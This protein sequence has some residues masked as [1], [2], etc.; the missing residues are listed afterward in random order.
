ME[1]ELASELRAR[2]L[3]SD[4]NKRVDGKDLA[5]GQGSE[6]VF[7]AESPPPPEK[8]NSQKVSQPIR[9]A[10]M[11]LF[12]DES[13]DRGTSAPSGSGPVYENWMAAARRGDYSTQTLGADRLL[14][15]EADK[16]NERNTKEYRDKCV[17]QA[18]LEV[19]HEYLNEDELQMVKDQI[20]RKSPSLWLEGSTRTVV[21]GFR[22]DVRTRGGPIRK[23]A[24]RLPPAES[25]MLERLI[26]EDMVRGQLVRIRSP[27]GAPAFL[28]KPAKAG[29]IE[30]KRRMVVDYRWVNGVTVRSFFIVPRADDQK[31]HVAG[32][33]FMTL[34]DGVS[35]FNQLLNTE[36]AT[37]ILAVVS[38]SGTYGPKCL[39]FGP[40]NGPEDFQACVNRMFSRRLGKDTNLFIDDAT[41]ATGKKRPNAVKEKHLKEDAEI[42]ARYKRAAKIDSVNYCRLEHFRHIDVHG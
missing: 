34:G 40:C 27:W 7:S 16:A 20:A 26:G 28:T 41:I 13:I 14:V 11:E 30:R 18:S 37:I 19:L 4:G 42:R 21:R 25:E 12:A 24:H 1:P 15:G 22:H 9:E 5:V 2:G 31:R 10:G 32:N 3:A 39:T 36:E 23:S 38:A 17:S 8:P 33:W 35:G 29:R 6:Q